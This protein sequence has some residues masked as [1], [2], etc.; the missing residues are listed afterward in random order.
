[1]DILCCY[2]V[3]GMNSVSTAQNLHNL[4]CFLAAKSTCKDGAWAPVQEPE[5]KHLQAGCVARTP[6]GMMELR[7]AVV[8]SHNED[9]NDN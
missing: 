4:I 8:S 7:S 6:K 5:S 1:M 9:E 2:T 3:T